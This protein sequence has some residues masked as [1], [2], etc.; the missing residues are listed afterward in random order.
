M[1]QLRIRVLNNPQGNNHIGIAALLIGESVP[2]QH[3]WSI[4]N[5]LKNKQEVVSYYGVESYNN[6]IVNLKVVKKK[7]K[8]LVD[9]AWSW[10][11]VDEA[12][13]CLL[14]AFPA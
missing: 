12:P 6:S 10:A 8:N 13:L 5:K 11:A 3:F 7:T 4:E 9:A 1:S 14:Y 2:E